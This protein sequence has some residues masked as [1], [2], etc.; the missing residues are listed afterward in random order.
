MG[1]GM[2]RLDPEDAALGRVMPPPFDKGDEGE[3]LHGN[4][5][6]NKDVAMVMKSMGDEEAKDKE[7]SNGEKLK[8]KSGVGRND[9]AIGGKEKHSSGAMKNAEDEL[10]YR[11]DNLT[12]GPGSPSFREYCNDYECGDRSSMEYSNDGDS[13]ENIK[14]GSEASLIRNNKPMN[15]GSVDSSK[16]KVKKE[17]RGLGFR[18]VI[19][20]GK[21]RRG[22]RNLLNF[23]CS[24]G[25][26]E[27]HAEGSSNKSVAK[28]EY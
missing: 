22:G 27:S 1:C 2:S 21:T 23:V 7:G 13:V 28:T 14:N 4:S 5:N 19:S 18:N 26:N 25:S 9:R 12:V 15:Q 24:S 20:K 6:N 17:G 3:L 8:E 16:E 11:D 10:E